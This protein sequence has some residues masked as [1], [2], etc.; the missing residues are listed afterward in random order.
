MICARGGKAAAPFVQA[1]MVLRWFKEAT[2]LRIL[3]RDAQVCSGLA[4]SHCGSCVVP[5]VTATAPCPGYSHDSQF[6]AGLE[7]ALQRR[8]LHADPAVGVTA[9]RNPVRRVIRT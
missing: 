1:V 9:E 6:P 5:N 8:E 7:L 3:A 4:P 2:D